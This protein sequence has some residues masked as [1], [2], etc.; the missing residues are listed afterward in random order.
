ME[1]VSE[2][3]PQ[4]TWRPENAQRK[5]QFPWKILEVGM[6]LTGVKG[7]SNQQPSDPTVGCFILP[8]SASRDG[9]QRCHLLKF[10]ISPFHWLRS[11]MKTELNTFRKCGIYFYLFIFLPPKRTDFGQFNL[12]LPQWDITSLPATLNQFL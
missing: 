11:R 6:C 8:E 10:L 9:H 7:L 3:D 2:R 4:S 12:F 1:R 5:L